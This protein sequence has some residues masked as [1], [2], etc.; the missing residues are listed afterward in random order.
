MSMGNS[1]K[2]SAGR[3]NLFLRVTK[4][5]FATGHS[6]TNYFI[7]VTPQKCRF[8]EARSVADELVNEYRHTTIIDTVL[9]ID[10]TEVIGTCIANALT[11]EDFANMNA[12]Q[13]VYV[14]R[15]ESTSASQLI[16]RDNTVPFISGKR[17]L[18]VCASVATGNTAKEAI[19][20]VKYYG[21]T[22]VG[23]TSIFSMTDSIDGIEVKSVFS[24]KK[25][26]PDFKNYDAHD[27]PLCKAGE[28]IDAL[29]NSY[30]YSK[31]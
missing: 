5:H 13:T 24:P 3:D 23:I 2:I 11:R 8:S 31:L 15:P 19:E 14:V 6:H 12:H 7:D 29:I 18:I 26:L 30:G 27:C 1:F 17:V 21:G 28:K 9:C 10:G 25:D 16:F 22:V 20:T 4:G